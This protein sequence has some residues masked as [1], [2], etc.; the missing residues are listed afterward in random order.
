M[1]WLLGSYGVATVQAVADVLSLAL[2]IPI[3]IGM[4]KKI[5]AAQRS[6]EAQP[7]G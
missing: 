5:D 3:I 1:A 7:V 2:A 6:L 4:K